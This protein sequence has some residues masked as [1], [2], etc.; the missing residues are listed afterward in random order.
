[1]IKAIIF[2][3]GRVISS[4][5]PSALFREYEKDLGLAPDSIN[6]IMFDSPLWE[7]AILGRKTAREFWFAIGPELGL[8]SREHIDAFRRRYHADESINEPVL[9]LI[10]R[11]HGRY[12]LAVLSNSPPG[13]V[14]WLAEWDLLEL[15]DEVFCSGDESLIKPDPAAYHLILKRLGILPQEAV[16]ID[17]TAGHVEAARKIGMHGIV[18]TKAAELEQALN[19]LLAF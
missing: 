2:D 12:K 18:F 4:P 11:L 15:F 5:K 7:D 6:R 3:F 8:K 1:M 14:E 10:R 16:F 17:D 13:L 9:N 19:P